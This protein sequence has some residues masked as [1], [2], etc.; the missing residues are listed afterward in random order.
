MRTTGRERLRVWRRARLEGKMAAMMRIDKKV[1]TVMA[2]GET[3]LWAQPEVEAI[4]ARSVAKGA[5]RL[6]GEEAV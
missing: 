2:G 5:L 6:A 4:D 3:A 1:M